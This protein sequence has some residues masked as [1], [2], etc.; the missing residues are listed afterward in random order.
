MHSFDAPL[1]AT[2]HH[3]GDLSGMIVIQPVDP[4]QSPIHIAWDD[5]QAFYLEQRRKRM[6]E[7][8]EN[9]TYDDLE[10]M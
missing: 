5:I 6:I 9:A 3:N 8:L 1:G 7:Q 10:S 2:F 4:N